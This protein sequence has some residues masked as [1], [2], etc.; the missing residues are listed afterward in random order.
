MYVCPKCAS[1]VDSDRLHARR[2]TCPDCGAL[3]RSDTQRQ[4]IDVARVNNL[5]EAGFLTDELLGMGIDAR[6]HQLQEF[7][8]LSNHWTTLYMI[9]VPAM[10]AREAAARI[11]QHLAEDSEE[12][13][14]QSTL[15]HRS[16]Q[17]ESLDV[18]LWRPVALVV[19]AG[20]ASFILGQ[21]WSD[22]NDPKI[23]RRP[24]RSSLAT[25][26]E[27]IGEPLVTQSA[28]GQ[29]RH[30]L[31]FDRKHDVWLLELDRDGDGLYDHRR[32]FHNFEKAW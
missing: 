20:V 3:L 23:D 14:A 22:R 27:A 17:D 12:S 32:V 15:F 19:L 21:R 8:A 5:A 6:I 9:R 13:Y 28:E 29:P 26:V 30:R 4:W 25:A 7:S 11:R 16:E 24:P 31:S 10:K 2:E 18:I 1:A